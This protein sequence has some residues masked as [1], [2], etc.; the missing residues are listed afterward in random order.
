MT[1]TLIH[2]TPRYNISEDDTKLT[3]DIA[4]PGV[5]RDAIQLSTEQ[6]T[7]TLTATRTSTK[8]EEWNLISASEAPESYQLKLK[9]NPEYD[10]ALTE[11]KFEQNVLRL[12]IP[13]KVANERTL[14]IQ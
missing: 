11:A 5:S 2:P 12:T 10:L 3:L 1:D 14:T 9:I 7:L 8:K 13:S 4:L 6:F